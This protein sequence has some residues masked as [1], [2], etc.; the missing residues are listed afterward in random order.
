MEEVYQSFCFSKGRVLGLQDEVWGQLI[1]VDEDVDEVCLIS[2]ILV[3][4]F[5][6]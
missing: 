5:L 2:T 6:A 3:R 4:C 1:G